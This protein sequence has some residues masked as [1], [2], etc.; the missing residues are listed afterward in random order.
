MKNIFFGMR[1][2]IGLRQFCHVSL[3]VVV[4]VL[5][6]CCWQL[7]QLANCSWNQKVAEYTAVSEILKSLKLMLGF[8]RHVECDEK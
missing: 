1:P 3:C 6:L 4:V 2:T 5:R 8:I 7:A